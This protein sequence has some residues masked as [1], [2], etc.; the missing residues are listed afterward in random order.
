MEWFGIAIKIAQRVMAWVFTSL[1][2]GKVTDKEWAELSVVIL[3]SIKD[4]GVDV[5]L[6]VGKKE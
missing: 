6:D 2:D 3:E 1:A 5:Q 4:A